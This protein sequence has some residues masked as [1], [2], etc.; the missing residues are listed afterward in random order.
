MEGDLP[1]LERLFVLRDE[2]ERC[3][4]DSRREGRYAEGSTGQRV[5]NPL[6]KH[7]TTLEASIDKLEA[8]FGLSP[9]ARLKLGVT[10][11]EAKRSL[12][13]ANAAVEAGDDEESDEELFG[14]LIEV[15]AQ[16]K[17]A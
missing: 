12:A 5:L 2:W 1:A 16:V 13:D 17:D 11:G 15:E 10:F 14:D 6:Y 9:L 7:M 4:R 8:Q 3:L